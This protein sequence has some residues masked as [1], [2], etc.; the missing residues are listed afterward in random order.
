MFIEPQ[1]E[2]PDKEVFTKLVNEGVNGT[3]L[4]NYD[5]D[6]QMQLDPGILRTNTG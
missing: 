3:D 2:S 5:F 4:D 1:F 6:G